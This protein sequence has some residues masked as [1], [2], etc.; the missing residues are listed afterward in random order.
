MPKKYVFTREFWNLDHPKVAHLS[1]QPVID[2]E[3]FV[4]SIRPEDPFMALVDHG[5]PDTVAIVGY[6]GKQV[7]EKIAQTVKHIREVKTRNG[8][9]PPD[10]ADKDRDVIAANFPASQEIYAK[11]DDMECKECKGGL[12]SR[13]IA[14]MFASCK[15]SPRPDL[16]A[17][18]K[19]PLTQEAVK[20]L[21]GEALDTENIEV[22]TP[23]DK[24][25]KVGVVRR[26][27]LFSCPIVCMGNNAEICGKCRSSREFRQELVKHFD[28]TP[29]FNV[30]RPD[31]SS[32]IVS[33]IDKP[34]STY[35]FACPY[36]EEVQN[37][38]PSVMKMAVNAASAGIRVLRAVVEGKD[39]TV[40]REE[41]VKREG[42]CR[43]CPKYESESHRCYEC[44]CHLDYKIPRTTEKCPLA[45]W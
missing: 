39:V 10:F 5:T 37:K 13:I 21:S 14:E 17:E 19:T 31:K 8:S 33:T 45:K 9:M 36:K 18:F 32:Y 27:Q 42:I 7:E 15:E 12:K 22:K 26:P 16:V 6:T 25:A 38:F 24:M 28:V 3:K 34:A 4:K 20:L 35:D 41:V 1:R 2:G 11:I 44:G 29:T 30:T 40:P 23:F 43:S